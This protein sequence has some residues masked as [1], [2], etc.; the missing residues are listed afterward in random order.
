M[1]NG[2]DITQSLTEAE[3]AAKESPI[4]VLVAGQ[5]QETVLLGDD[6]EMMTR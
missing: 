6:D 1:S 3:V 2:A 4:N 5:E